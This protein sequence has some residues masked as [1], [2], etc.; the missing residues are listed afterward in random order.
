[1]PKPNKLTPAEKARILNLARQGRTRAS[2]AKEVGRA[3]TTVAKVC[4]DADMEPA[5]VLSAPFVEARALSIKERQ[6]AARERRLRIMELEDARQLDVLEGRAMWKTRVKTQGG[7]EYFETVDFIPP[8]DSRNNS[9]TAA[10]HSSAF[11]NLAP[12]EVEVGIQEA[13][14]MLDKVIESLDVPDE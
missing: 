13:K 5:V 10:S 8:D 1:V 3:V 12:L 7:G 4:R 9:S 11:R 2:I 6:V 14:S